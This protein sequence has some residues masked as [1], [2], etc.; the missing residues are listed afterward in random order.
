MKNLKRLFLLVFCASFLFTTP[1][2]VV[3][4]KQDNGRHLG[5]YKQKKKAGPPAQRGKGK[6]QRRDKHKDGQR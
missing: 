5:W 3:L 2:C 1:A 4:H 6:G